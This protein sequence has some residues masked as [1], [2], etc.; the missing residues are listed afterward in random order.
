MVCHDC[1]R[2]IG[3]VRI[4]EAAHGARSPSA[5]PMQVQRAVLCTSRCPTARQR[6]KLVLRA[7]LVRDYRKL[8]AYCYDAALSIALGLDPD[9]DNRCECHRG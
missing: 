4:V 9:D 2:L 8:C 1:E 5:P 3:D 6:F 7:W